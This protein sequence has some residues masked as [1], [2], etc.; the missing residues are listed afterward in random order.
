MIFTRFDVD[1]NK[2]RQSI[3]KFE[4]FEISISVNFIFK[5]QQQLVRFEQFEIIKNNV[6]SSIII[7]NIFNVI[8]NDFITLV[9]DFID[10]KINREIELLKIEFNI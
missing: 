2:T 9:R 8:V 6:Q 1:N 3:V 7:Q 10:V 4:K 5:F